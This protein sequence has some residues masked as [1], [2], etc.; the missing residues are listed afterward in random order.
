MAEIKPNVPAPKAPLA[1][2]TAP[3]AASAAPAGATAPAKKSIFSAP[4]QKQKKAK[5]EEKKRNQKGAIIRF[6]IAAVA[7]GTYSFFF[8]YPT[9]QSYLAYGAD[10]D[11][12]EENIEIKE[13]I[14]DGLKG[15]RDELKTEFDK[16][17]KEEIA[18]I[19]QVF[20]AATEKLNVI[21]LMEDYAAFLSTTYGNFEFS[22]IN[23]QNSIK[24]KKYTILPFQ[25]NIVSSR[26]NFDR[27]L[28]L[29]DLSGQLEGEDHIRLM[30]ISNISLNYLGVDPKTGKDKGVTFNVSLN[31]YSRNEK[32]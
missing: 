28:G 26:E 27:F 20:P 2:S 4:L 32:S 23:F 8:F 22:A 10:L 12:I 18:V 29:I 24:E 14:I 6:L 3:V 5:M 30:D 1:A 16:K 21:R 13:G 11:V 17:N 7:V 15:Q 19:N 9:L 31:A 25:T